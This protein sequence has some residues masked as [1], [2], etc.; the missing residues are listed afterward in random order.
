[1]EINC[2]VRSF[3]LQQ[4]QCHLQDGPCSI[5]TPGKSGVC[6]AIGLMPIKSK[7]LSNLTPPKEQESILEDRYRHKAHRAR[8]PWGSN[9]F[10]FPM[11]IEG[12]EGDR[13][14]PEVNNNHHKHIE[15]KAK[16][17]VDG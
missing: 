3:G 5:S 14:L 13:L 8:Y 7:S 12:K 6:S 1:M 16:N 4:D 2:Y 9:N 17:Q 10:T 15:K 11:T